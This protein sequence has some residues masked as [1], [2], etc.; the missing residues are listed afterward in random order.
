[1]SPV[2]LQSGAVA[3]YTLGDMT[4]REAQ[5]LDRARLAAVLPVGAIEAHGPHLPLATDVIIAAGMA[6]EGAARMSAAGRE[7][8]LLPALAYTSAGYAASFPGTVSVRPETLTALVR[9]IAAS[10][11]SQGV[12]VLAVANAHLEPAH[13]ASLGRAVEAARAAGGIAIA[14]PDVTRKPWALRLTDE[15]KSGACHAGRFEG[16]IV[17]AQRPDLVR[18]EIRTKLPPNPA[19]LSKAIRDGKRTFEEAGG[20]KAYFGDPAAASRAEGLESI[21]TLGTI[22]EDAMRGIR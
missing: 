22:L 5:A 9:D 17:M 1:M 8:L 21:A 11:V 10:L 3:V 16:S 2:F 7:V 15:F 4:W 12:R 6:R 20:P 18:E 19:S 13:I 14:F